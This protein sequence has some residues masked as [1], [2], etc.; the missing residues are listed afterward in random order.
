MIKILIVDDQLVVRERLSLALQQQADFR[1][2][3][4][5]ANGEEAIDLT[6]LLQPDLVLL[7]IEMPGA[8]GLEVASILRDRFP[9]VRT[10]ILSSRDDA[11]SIRNS[12]KSGV[13]GYVAKQKIDASM[14]EIIRSVHRG[15]S[16]FGP[17][18]LEKVITQTSALAVAEPLRINIVP[19][20]AS[21][22]LQAPQ[23]ST[24]I[25]V[26]EPAAELVTADSPVMSASLE[27]ES[28]EVADRFQANAVT[29]LTDWSN[30][31][32]EIIDG[33]P[34]PW[35]RGLFY[36][37]L[38]FMSIALP[39]AIFFQMDEIG[40]ARG[41]LELTGDTVKREADLPGNATVTK[42]L[43]KKGDTV[44]KGQVIMELDAKEIRDQIQQNQVKLEGQQQRLNQLNLSKNQLTI[45]LSTQQ[46]QG[47]AQLGEKQTQIAQA[48]QSLSGLK[49]SYSNQASEKN[50][51]LDQATQTVRDRQNS[52]SQ[53]QQ[54]K[55]NQVNQA[56][57]TIIDSTAAYNLAKNRFQDAQREVDRYNKLLRQGAI[58]E[59]RSRE[60]ESTAKERSQTTVQSQASL[61]Q[62]KLRLK[63]QQ[64]SYQKAM[65]QAE[66]DIK[67][68][69]L[70]LKEQ[71]GNYQ[72]TIGQLQSDI[73]QAELRIKEQQNSLQSLIQT[74][75]LALVKS[76]QQLKELQSQIVTLE[77][78]ILQNKQ[79]GQILAD[80]LE[81]YTIRADVDGSIFELPVTREGAVMQPK[82]LIAEIAPASKGGKTDLIF[83]GEIPA[84][85]SE[86]LRAQGVGKEVKLKFDEFP[87]AT[88][89]I[90]QGKLIW[91]SP[92]S[93]VTSSITGA[94]STSYEVKIALDKPCLTYKEE[95]LSFKSGQP[96]TAEI[97]IRRRRILNLIADPFTKLKG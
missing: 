88:Y 21:A 28:I 48:E 19:P 49:T 33:V 22:P 45:A 25:E 86:S 73:A 17:G 23:D 84:A 35:T 50:A 5:A 44:T 94:S 13:N 82:Q 1:V 90:V 3:G 9:Q 85:E 71:Q 77:N 18:L 81:K 15:N 61:Q 4:T 70:R 89:G 69:Q 14:V 41:R 2:V 51:Q 43:V 34:L 63:E 6:A 75:K 66:A 65:Q 56:K 95:C 8:S 58:P 96:A 11:D 60:A 64:D 80:R 24:E 87:F 53:Q 83:K 54:E 31:A 74:N 27:P 20:P 10:I 92:N 78:E 30:A 40:T 68:A 26:T 93:K 57:Q 12:L 16:Q 76:E 91:I 38:A 32:K 62:A 39:W 97:V 72:R 79:T 29:R 42:V 55:T 46:Q 7:D 59:I 37:L 47:Q 36:S 67:Q 52:L